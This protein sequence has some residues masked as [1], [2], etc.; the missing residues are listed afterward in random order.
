MGQRQQSAQIPVSGFAFDQQSQMGVFSGDRTRRPEP[1]RELRSRN[2]P[3]AE[4]LAG[5]GE[6]HRA[7]DA[8]VVGEGEGGITLSGGGG[9]QLHRSRG[10]VEEREGGVRVQLDVHE[11]STP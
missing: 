6:L 2:R 7:P 1:H 9:G 4:A 5:V 10:A 11:S 8:V 3:D